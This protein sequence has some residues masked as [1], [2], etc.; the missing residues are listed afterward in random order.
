M[1][2]PWTGYGASHE[3]RHR[4]QDHDAAARSAS[5]AAGDRGKELAEHAQLS[6]D[7]GVQV[8]FADPHSP[9]QRGTNENTDGRLRQYFPKGTDLSRW[10]AEE[11]EAVAMALSNRPRKTLNWRRP[12]EALNDHLHRFNQPVLRRPIE[13]GLS[14]GIGVTCHAGRAFRVTPGHL[15][16]VEHHGGAHVAG[17]SPPDDHPGVRVYDEVH[18]GHRGPGRHECQ[19]GHS[20]LVGCDGGEPC[21][22]PD[23]DVSAGRGVR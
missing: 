7:T 17:D 11:I 3:G 6:I 18:I 22:R 21:G 13:P 10:D 20:Q 8:Y 19:I 1:A 4:R 15:Q 16:C 9:W 2:P 23:R 5:N 12:A 14:A